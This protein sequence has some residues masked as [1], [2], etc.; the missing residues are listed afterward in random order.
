[1]PSGG[2]CS[3]SYPY[4]FPRVQLIPRRGV[5]LAVGVNTVEPDIHVFRKEMQMSRK[6]QYKSEI[7]LLPHLY[8]KLL[9]VTVLKA[10]FSRSVT[11]INHFL[12]DLA[13]SS[14]NT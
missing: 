3:L 6:G 10:F 9:Q 5:F 11:L 1:M 8:V 12:A 2:Y 14:S 4:P 7:N 13:S